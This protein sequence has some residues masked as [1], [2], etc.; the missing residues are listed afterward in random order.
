MILIVYGTTTRCLKFKLIVR[1]R[2]IMLDLSVHV[3]QCRATT[4]SLVVEQAAVA[5][6][7]LV[8]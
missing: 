4:S 7:Q 1:E 5:L 2:D 8:Q 3:S 6:A